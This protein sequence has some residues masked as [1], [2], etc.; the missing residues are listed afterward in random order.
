[1]NFLLI[2]TFVSVTKFQSNINCFHIAHTEIKLWVIL[3]S[4]IFNFKSYKHFCVKWKKHWVPI[5]T[6]GYW[7]T[8]SKYDK[9][10]CVYVCV[11]MHARMHKMAQNKGAVNCHYFWNLLYNVPKEITY[12]HKPLQTCMTLQMSP[13][14]YIGDFFKSDFNIFLNYSKSWRPDFKVN[15]EGMWPLARSTH[16][17][18]KLHLTDLKG[19]D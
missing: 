9:M 19:T 10:V 16:S 6:S 4:M 13:K 14:T 18:K 12:I 5:Y 7:N 8:L 15:H 3:I 17:Q 2:L 1:M 11:Y